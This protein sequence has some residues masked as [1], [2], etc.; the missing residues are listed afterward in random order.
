MRF[1]GWIRA[2][3]VDDWKF[4]VTR[5]F[6]FWI[7]A[8]SAVASGMMWGFTPYGEYWWPVGVICSAAAL[9]RLI[10]QERKADANP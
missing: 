8:A 5:S 1:V 2:R 7:N 3:I 9:G 10:K 4:V 6:S